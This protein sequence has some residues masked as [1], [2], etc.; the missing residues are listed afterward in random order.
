MKEGPRELANRAMREAKFARGRNPIKSSGGAP[1]ERKASPGQA[2]D[3]HRPALKDA[4][5]LAVPTSPAMGRT[6]MNLPPEAKP[7]RG[8]PRKP[9]AELSRASKYR[10]KAEGT[11]P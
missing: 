3:N 2:A 11:L 9:D 1:K 6:L 4:P 8:R 7:K 10:R 5:G